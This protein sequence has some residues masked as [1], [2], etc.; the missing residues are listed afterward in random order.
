MSRLIAT[1]V[2]S[3]NSPDN[4]PDKLN[5]SSDT[6]VSRFAASYN[7]TK[8]GTNLLTISIYPGDKNCTVGSSKVSSTRVVAWGLNPSKEESATIKVRASDD[9][10]QLF[11][12]KQTSSVSEYDTIS[13][14]VLKKLN[15]TVDIDISTDYPYAT[16]TYKYNTDKSCTV[17]I[18][19]KI[20]TLN[21]TMMHP[22][23]QAMMRDQVSSN[24]FIKKFNMITLDKRIKSPWPSKNGKITNQKLV[25]DKLLVPFSPLKINTPTLLVGDTTT[26]TYNKD[27]H[28]APTTFYINIVRADVTPEVLQMRQ[29]FLDMQT[30]VSAIVSQNLALRIADGTLDPTRSGDNIKISDF[31]ALNTYKGLLQSFG[32]VLSHT[33]TE[34]NNMTISTSN[35][36]FSTDVLKLFVS[37]IDLESGDISALD[38]LVNSLVDGLSSFSTSDSSKQESVHEF[39]QITT[40]TED[41]LGGFTVSL[42]LVMF[43]ADTSEIN[44]TFSG[45]CNTH[46]S[47][48][49]MDVRMS[50]FTEVYDFNYSIYSKSSEKTV[51]QQLVQHQDEL[52]KINKFLTV[53]IDNKP[54]A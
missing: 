6:S 2:L 7:P 15:T 36:S 11:T 17:F 14:N 54:S 39:V 27:L 31:R 37:A 32:G 5:I 41:P 33:K 21:S 46:Y 48:T 3:V 44:Q 4:S 51:V 53:N 16:L 22:S 25:V 50:Y 29:D 42:R 47:H 45:A 12:S 10:V 28:D 49:E 52:T 18:A 20:V 9:N 34:S 30:F 19:E 1:V 40:I 38:N 35:T 13:A 24:D 43:E 23:L 8:V 26:P